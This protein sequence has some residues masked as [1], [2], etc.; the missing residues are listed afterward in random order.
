VLVGHASHTD[1][2]LPFHAVPWMGQPGSEV[3]VAGQDQQPFRI[4]VETTDGI[5]VLPDTSPREQIHDRR[6]L[7]RVRS[8]RDVA[9]RL[10]QEKIATPQRTL[11]PAAVYANVVRGRIRLRPKL[12]D[13]NTVDADPT[14]LNQRLGCTP[15]RYPCGRQNFLKP[16]LHCLD[17]DI[18]FTAGRR[19]A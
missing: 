15:G 12:A 6:P 14:L 1:F 19:G 2:V 16:Y 11:D 4:V 13:G 7:L 17:D 10:I 9:A 18:Q 5:D 3:T 8:G